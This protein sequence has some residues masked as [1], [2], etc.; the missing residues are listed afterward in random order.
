MVSKTLRRSFFFLYTY[1]NNLL[2]SPISEDSDIDGDGV[3]NDEDHD[4]DGDG[5]SNSEEPQSMDIDGDG[6][7]NNVD[8]DIDGDNKVNE[9]DDD[10]DGDGILNEHDNDMDGDGI[11]NDHDD[12]RETVDDDDEEEEVKKRSKREVD[13]APVGEIEAPPSPA[14]EFPAEEEKEEEA[15]E[16][17]P[18]AAVEEEP[19][20]EEEPEVEAEAEAEPAPEA[21]AQPAVAVEQQEE[22][23]EVEEKPVEEAVEPEPEA[24]G[25]AAEE[26][27]ADET[28]VAAEDAIDADDEDTKPEDEL[29]WVSGKKTQKVN[30]LSFDLLF[31][32]PGGCRSTESSQPSAH[33]RTAAP[34][35][36]IQCT[37]E[38]H[39]QCRWDNSARHQEDLWERHQATG[40]AVQV[41]WLEQSSLWRSRDL[42]KAVDPVHGSLVGRQVLHSQLSDG[43]WIYAQLVENR[44][45]IIG[46]QDVWESRLILLGFSRRGTVAG[47]LQHSDVGQWDGSARR[48]PAGSRL[49]LL[50]SAEV[51]PGSGRA[52]ARPEIE[53][54][55]ARKGMRTR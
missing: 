49:Y 48:H 27:Q 50:R 3:H 30:A 23:V 46:M 1:Y 17:E 34:G 54:Q 51:R 41:S 36:G 31:L 33:H 42:L 5:L 15:A 43:Q 37:R 38:G 52:S 32:F 7:P 4:V 25:E 45:G 53:E 28:A 47:L 21:E 11:P 12:S 19:V 14:E 13:A 26:P 2:N 44:Y 18:E 22:A 8:D 6:V 40:D 24:S 9:K 16:A 55:A 39:R 10:M 20:K 29:L 35:W